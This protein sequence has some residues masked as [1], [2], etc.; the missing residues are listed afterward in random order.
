MD[1]IE[2]RKNILEK[3]K[4]L[5]DVSNDLIKKLID[6]KILDNCNNIGIYYPLPY[7]VNVLPLLK[8]YKDKCFCFPKTIGNDILFYKENDLKNFLKGK[9]NVMEPKSSD[10]VNSD[11][12]D[13]FIIPCVGIDSFN[14]RIGYGKG[15]YD[16]YLQNY[17]GLKIALI[18]KEL[19]LD[20]KVCDDFDIKIDKVFVG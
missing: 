4:S 2:V 13:A 1:K 19:Y 3:R 7:E 17:K 6:S 11:K 5:Y 20:F 12:I 16:R 10:L 8:Y 18:N 9:F 14:R 15:Y